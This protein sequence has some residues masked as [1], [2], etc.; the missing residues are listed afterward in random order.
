MNQ[1]LGFCSSTYRKYISHFPV[2]LLYTV[3]FDCGEGWNLLR[4]SVV[5]VGWVGHCSRRIYST[6]TVL[7]KEIFFKMPN[8]Q[9]AYILYVS[10][11]FKNLSYCPCLW[12]VFVWTL[13]PFLECHL[14]EPFSELISWK[15]IPCEVKVSLTDSYHQIATNIHP[16]P[17]VS[18]WSTNPQGILLI[19]IQCDLFWPWYADRTLWRSLL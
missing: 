2:R 14:L 1:P 5:E 8:F 17:I 12:Q 16:H 11:A 19:S 13:Y 3:S 9:H 10:R 4:L 7:S 15:R 6:L 18:S